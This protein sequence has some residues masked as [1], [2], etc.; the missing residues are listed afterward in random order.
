MG[1]GKME[2]LE[3]ERSLLLK[4]LPPG[5]NISKQSGTKTPRICSLQNMPTGYFFQ[6]R[7]AAS[8]SLPYL[9]QQSRCQ[10]SKWLKPARPPTWLKS[11]TVY[12]ECLNGHLQSH[13]YYLFLLLKSNTEYTSSHIGKYPQNYFSVSV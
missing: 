6:S 12:A 3:E 7:L 9:E 11:H 5:G 1:W 2:K 10:N 8:K 4:C 13:S